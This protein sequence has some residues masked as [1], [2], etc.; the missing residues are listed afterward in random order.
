MCLHPL[1]MKWNPNKM[2]LLKNCVII[3]F[4]IY[5]APNT[6]LSALQT[7]LKTNSLQSKVLLNWNKGDRIGLYMSKKN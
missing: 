4:V 6:V 1:A 7:G 3:Y 2:V 5:I